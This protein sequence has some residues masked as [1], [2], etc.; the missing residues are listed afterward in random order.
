M[1]VLHILY[2]GLGGHGNV[3]FSLIDA[4]I[5]KEFEYEA[6]FNG[7][8]KLKMEY[9]QR[10][11]KSK[12]KYT[13]VKKIPGID[14]GYYKHIANTIKNS[15]PSIIF[16]HSSSYI[17]PVILV[18]ILGGVKSTIVVRE[19]QANNLKTKKEWFW[20]TLA[21]LFADKCIFLSENYRME[22]KKYLPLFFK[23]KKIFIIP[24]GINLNKFIP[25]EKI[26]NTHVTIGMQ[27]RV[28]KIK[29]HNTLLR[30]FA[31]LT[32]D[33]DLQHV[34]ILLKIAGDGENLQQLKKLSLDLNIEQ[35]VIF[36]GVL[37]EDEIVNFLNELDIYVHASLGETMS[38][39]IMQAMANEKAIIASDVPGINNMISSN[40]NG[41]LVPVQNAQVLY[42]KIKF[43][44]NNPNI[45]MQLANNAKKYARHNFSNE[46]MFSKYRDLFYS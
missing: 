23:E 43:L 15:N 16:L 4:D 14:I 30:S 2:S 21:L 3:F 7:V 28:I 10:C 44:I 37:N 26:K 20:L 8:E 32:N 31:L 1:K 6:L 34:N 41:I 35:K 46:V 19:T 42:E 27:S 17:L 12:I 5:N 33:A 36:V 40:V 18:R 9:I 29:D 11:E 25:L 13:Y 22:I 38:T 45:K 39:S 24:N